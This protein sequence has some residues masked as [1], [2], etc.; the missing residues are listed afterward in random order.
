MIAALGSL[1]GKPRVVVVLVLAPR[2]L[3]TRDL[4]ALLWRT[5]VARFGLADGRV[6]RVETG[7]I[8]LR[9]TTL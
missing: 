1:L 8:F 2:V 6:R 7:S 4:D 9:R 3:A 5:G